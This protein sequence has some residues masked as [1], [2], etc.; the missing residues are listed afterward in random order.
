MKQSFLRHLQPVWIVK[1]I[2]FCVPLVIVAWL[3]VD[4]LS[5]FGNLS[6]TYN[7]SGESARVK[8]FTPAGRALDRE[9]NLR[10]GETYQRIVGEP[11]YMNVTVPRSYDDVSVTL[12]YQNDG[13]PYTEFGLVTSE[14]PLSVRLQS[15]DIGIINQAINEGWSQIE[16]DGVTLLQRQSEFESVAD[17]VDQTPEDQ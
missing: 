1:A 10:T 2:I 8:E 17:F 15:L 5:I 3:T 6:I 12:D 9:Q 7:F 16:S 4:Y 11:V 13:Q 14:E